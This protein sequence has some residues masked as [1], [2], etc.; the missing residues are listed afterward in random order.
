MDPNEV[1]NIYPNNN[2]K[3]NKKIKKK[4]KSKRT[5]ARTERQA[6]IILFLYFLFI[7]FS[8]L[9]KSDRRFSSEQK[10]KL[11]YATRATRRYQKLSI[12]SHFK[13]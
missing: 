13:K 4:I 10:T 12:S 9:W 2:K 5:D 1:I 8:D 11:V 7:S 3:K 6:H